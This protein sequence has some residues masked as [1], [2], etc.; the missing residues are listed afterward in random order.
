M[1]ESSW[2]VRHQHL[3]IQ[4]PH[5]LEVVSIVVN[6]RSNLQ[7]CVV[8]VYHR[9]QLP[10]SSFLPLLDS[11]LNHVTH[12]AMATVILGDFNENLRSCTNSRLLQFMSSIGFSQLVQHPTTDSGSLL[13]HIYYN[14]SPDGVV[15]VVDTYYSDHDACF[16]SLHQ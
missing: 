13:D 4:H 5:S 9:P 8:A 15:D 14:Q 7:M 6:T 10:I 3:N 12:Q 1:E 11:Y 16:L 2:H